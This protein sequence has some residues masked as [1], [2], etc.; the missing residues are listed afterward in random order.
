MP[1]VRG[2]DPARQPVRV[3]VVSAP[4]CPCCSYE[5]IP[6]EPYCFAHGCSPG[7]CSG[8]E[9]CD[10]QPSWSEDMPPVACETGGCA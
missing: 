7:G 4:E 8:E 5:A 1:D 10:V 2:G 6:G 9:G 3:R